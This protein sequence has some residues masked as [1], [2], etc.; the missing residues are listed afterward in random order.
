MCCLGWGKEDVASF[1][2][3]RGWGAGLPAC[4]PTHPVLEELPEEFSSESPEAEGLSSEW[5][6][7]FAHA[8]LG[9]SPQF[10]TV[11]IAEHFFPE[12]TKLKGPLEAN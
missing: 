6:L 3:K 1:L 9:L 4:L 5:R 2:C 12:I 8:G 11:G 7:T 10:S